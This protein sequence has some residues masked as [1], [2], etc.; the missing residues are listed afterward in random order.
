MLKVQVTP[1]DI[2]KLGAADATQVRFATVVALNRAARAG[3]EATQAEMR[4]VF[5]SPTAWVLGGVRY[6]KATTDKLVSQVDF[7]FWGNKQ[8]VT[9]EGVLQAEIL[10]GYRKLKRFEVAL[11]RIGVLPAGMYAVPGQGAKLDTHGNMPAGQLVQILAWFRAFGEQGYKANMTDKTRARLRK[12]S[13]KRNTHGFEYVAIPRINRGGL[14]P[15][16][17]QRFRF[18]QGTSLKPI[19]IFVRTPRYAARLRFFEVADTAARATFDTQFPLALAQARA[20]AR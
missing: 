8:S 1:S 19:L 2:A 9:V 14:Q 17:Y 5:D 16:I 20:T 18:A 6:I 3:A 15:G 11:Q 4:R 13:A 12:G 7:D 10:G